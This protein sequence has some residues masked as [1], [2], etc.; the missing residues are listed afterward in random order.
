M[1]QQTG[2]LVCSWREILG[3]Q[4]ECGHCIES[5]N[6]PSLKFLP[7]SQGLFVFFRRFKHLFL[8]V[9][10]NRLNL[11]RG[12]IYCPKS[13]TRMDNGSSSLTFTDGSPRYL[14][15][16]TGFLRSQS[17][18]VQQKPPVPPRALPQL[19]TNLS[20]P[21]TVG[22]LLGRGGWCGGWAVSQD[23]DSTAR[24]FVCCPSF[25]P[26]WKWKVLGFALFCM[27]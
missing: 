5:R 9:K 18:R 20:L 23:Q 7:T 15:V 13:C 6:S 8:G 21:G 19:V 12:R 10:V 17:R 22:A 26:E 4:R 11:L 27:L 16:C 2:R 3:T 25:A 24:A 1:F 14:E